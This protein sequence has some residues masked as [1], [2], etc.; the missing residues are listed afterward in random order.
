M[1][2][3]HGFEVEGVVI[4]VLGNRTYQVELVNG[5]RLVAFVAGKARA[6]AVHFDRGDKVRLE[7]SPYDLST[8][9]LLMEPGKI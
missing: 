8:G 2:R 6:N 4:E 7:V 5:H 3:T 9:R 1:A